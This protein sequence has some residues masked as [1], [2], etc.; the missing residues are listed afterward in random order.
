M[1]WL[2]LWSR[3]LFQYWSNIVE[4]ERHQNGEIFFTLFPL[5]VAA[6]GAA[7]KLPE[8]FS[9]KPQLLAL[10]HLTYQMRVAEEEISILAFF[11]YHHW[12]E[13]ETRC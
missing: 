13:F 5:L 2:L 9:L 10:P 6:G 12:K 7:G 11:D 3:Y 4:L 8:T 1:Y